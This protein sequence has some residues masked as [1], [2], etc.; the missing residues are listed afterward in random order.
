[1]NEETA[2][3]M[4]ETASVPAAEQAG[5]P[6]LDF[7]AFPNQ[8]F[9]LVVCLVILYMIVSRIALPRIEGILDHRK[10]RIQADLLDAEALNNEAVVLRE[11]N[12]ER[13]DEARTTA[14]SILAAARSTI[15]EIQETALADASER[16]NS[17]TAEADA[18]IDEIR[19]SARDSVAEIAHAAAKE[20][21]S[22]ML[23]GRDNATQV[24]SAVNAR[25]NGQKP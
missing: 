23:P 10:K 4:P 2:N 18:R 8:I 5:I 21:V 14:E 17:R 13:L 16:I 6:Q 20:I 1:M 11:K 7:A 24:S 22:S 25:A 9:W 12:V 19:R 15:R 3:L